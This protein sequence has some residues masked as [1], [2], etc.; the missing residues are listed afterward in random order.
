MAL[1]W[2]ACQASS[3]SSFL[4]ILFNSISSQLSLITVHVEPPAQPYRDA[5]WN[6]LSTD[7]HD[8]RDWVIWYVFVSTP[9]FVAFLMTGLKNGVQ[10]VGPWDTPALME[11]RGQHNRDLGALLVGHETLV[12]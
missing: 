10:L 5:F 6:L 3:L 4:L 8:F 1:A 2:R 7:K 12:G 9:F 11:V